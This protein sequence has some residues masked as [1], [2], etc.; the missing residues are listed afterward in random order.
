MTNKP[1]ADLLDYRVCHDIFGWQFTI[2]NSG[3]SSCVVIHHG[4]DCGPARPRHAVI[5]AV[6][7]YYIR[8]PQPLVP[9]FSDAE[10]CARMVAVLQ[11]RFGIRLVR[12]RKSKYRKRWM[13][14]CVGREFQSDD[15]RQVA[16]D[17]VAE[18]RRQG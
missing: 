18:I 1:T 10:S 17:A 4:I 16:L 8:F 14:R 5:T 13:A 2:E 3:N 6:A 15:P 9:S 12:Q 7:A 11:T